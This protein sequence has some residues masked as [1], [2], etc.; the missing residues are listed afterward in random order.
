MKIKRES[1]FTLAET[2]VVIAILGVLIILGIAGYASIAET[3]RISAARTDAQ[4]ASD[5]LHSAYLMRREVS[6]AECREHV[7][8]A[9]PGYTE[10]GTQGSRY[11]I[12]MDPADPSLVERVDFLMEINGDL[13]I[14]HKYTIATD[15]LKAVAVT[16]DSERGED[17]KNAGDVDDTCRPT[18]GGC[19]I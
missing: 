6:E 19:G 10:G 12:V 5:S 18:E 17:L 15:D 4:L 14:W 7:E 8:A 2:A 11:K 1:G 3:N 13:S 16:E 9:L